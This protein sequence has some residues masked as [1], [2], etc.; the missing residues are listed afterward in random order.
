V[1]FANTI[2]YLCGVLIQNKSNVMKYLMKIGFPTQQ[3]NDRIAGTDFGKKMQELLSEVKAD[4]TYFTVIDGQRGC[5]ILVEIADATQMPAKAE[6]FFHWLNAT[7]EFFPVMLL[8]DFEKAGPSL[9]SAVQKW[10]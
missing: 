5:F 4:A 7:I 3:T 9:G 1:F 8:D 2:D 6:P 10:A